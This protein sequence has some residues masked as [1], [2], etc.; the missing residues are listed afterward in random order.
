MPPERGILPTQPLLVVCKV[1]IELVFRFP[2][3]FGVNGV[4]F[5]A[6]YFVLG[7]YFVGAWGVSLVLHGFFKIIILAVMDIVRS[8]FMAVMKGNVRNELV[9]ARLARMP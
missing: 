5:F 7:A 3:S 4:A 1:L 8:I 6:F 2:F 9:Y